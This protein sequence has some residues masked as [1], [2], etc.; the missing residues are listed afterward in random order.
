[1]WSSDVCSSDLDVA[2][3][4]NV[5]LVIDAGNAVTGV[6]APR[7]F[8]ELGCD[9]T[10]LYCELDGSFPNHDPDPCHEK[11][12]RDLIAKVQ[13]VG[14][15]LGVAFDGDGDRLVVVTP[16]GRIIWPDHLLMLFARDVLARNPG[17]DVLFDVKCSRQRAHL[18][19]DCSS[20]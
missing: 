12:L 1:D 14:A 7:L 17:A 5:S 19:R 16:K 13:E 11:N 8:E 6:V 3:A 18:H 20:T 9:V 4:S 15:D 2:L 10:Q